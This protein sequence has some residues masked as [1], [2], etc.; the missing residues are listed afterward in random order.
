MSVLQILI[1]FVKCGRPCPNKNDHWLQHDCKSQLAHEY[2]FY[3]SFE[4]SIC[5][6]YITEKL[7]GVL[8]YDIIPVV[9]GWGPYDRHIPKSAYINAF[10]FESPKHLADYMLHVANNVTLYNSYFQ[11]K[12]YVRYVR[13]PSTASICEMCI[14]L[15]L[16]QYYGIKHSVIDSLN[17][18]WND[19]V[20]CKQLDSHTF[21]LVPW[22][23][24]V[25][26]LHQGEYFYEY[27]W[28]K[29]GVLVQIALI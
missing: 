11:W 9:Y 1:L 4:N 22:P 5:K 6:D 23:W 12:Q 26:R 17:S 29:P 27:S 10:D 24:V 14:M 19:T 15:N 18:F 3:M 2:K 8:R 16:E 28:I 7:F 13:Y 25:F 20:E 21:K